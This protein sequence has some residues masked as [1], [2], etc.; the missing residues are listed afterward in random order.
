M[1]YTARWRRRPSPTG[2]QDGIDIDVAGAAPHPHPLP[3]LPK[4]GR[5]RDHEH[6]MNNLCSVPRD[7]SGVPAGRWGLGSVVWAQPAMR[8]AA[9]HRA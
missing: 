9:A 5:R 4:L 2:A 1:W 6:N 7:S 3:E 8:W